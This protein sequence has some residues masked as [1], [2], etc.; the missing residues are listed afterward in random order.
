MTAR[1]APP[2]AEIA[3]LALALLVIAAIY[4]VSKL[5]DIPSLTLPSILLGASAALLATAF[6]LM[7]RIEDFAWRRF[8]TVAKWNGLAYCVS[9]GLIEYS[10]IRNDTRGDPL[11]VLTLSIVVYA[12]IVPLLVAF[13]VAHY[14]PDD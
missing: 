9:A 10:F 14:V 6:V 13:T 11:L 3:M 4:L 1:K 12:M 7:S 8:W 2:V 5:P